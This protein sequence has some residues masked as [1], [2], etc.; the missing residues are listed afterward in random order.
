[1]FQ[2]FK[3]LG[4]YTSYLKSKT[5]FQEVICCPYSKDE[6]RLSILIRILIHGTFSPKRPILAPNNDMKKMKYTASLIAMQ[7]KRCC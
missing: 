1:M 6:H 7:S 4:T 2:A 5:S 3:F